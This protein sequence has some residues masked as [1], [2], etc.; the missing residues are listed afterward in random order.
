LVKRVLLAKL[1]VRVHK[2]ILVDRDH[3]AILG[4]KEILGHREILDH[5]VLMQ[6]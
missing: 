2:A 1:E 4:R 6:R 3:K 5:L